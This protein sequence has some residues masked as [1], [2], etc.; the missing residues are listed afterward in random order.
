[1]K[2]AAVGVMARGPA[3]TV[4]ALIDRTLVPVV[5]EAVARV[6]SLVVARVSGGEGDL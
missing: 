5:S 1:M 2:G 3:G 6:A 4:G